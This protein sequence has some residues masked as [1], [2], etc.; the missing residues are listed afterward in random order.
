MAEL[1]K[2]DME[3]FNLSV[4]AVI[5]LMDAKDPNQKTLTELR[6][7]NICAGG[8]FVI[9][10]DPLKLGM[11]VD[12]DLRLAFFTGDTERERRS[13]IHVSGSIIRIEPGGMAIKFNEKY[14]IS[15]VL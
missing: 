11:Q 2:R 7:K 15:P 9:T 13:N 5:T 3:R 10:T 1:G 8:A 12:I 14:Q 6:T 4:P